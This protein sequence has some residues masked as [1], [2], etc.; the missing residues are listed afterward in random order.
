MRQLLFFGV[1]QSSKKWPFILNNMK[2]YLVLLLFS[3]SLWE[4]RAFMVPNRA[5][6]KSL[7]ELK[8]NGETRLIRGD[9]ESPERISAEKEELK[10]SEPLENWHSIEDGVAGDQFRKPSSL[11][12]KAAGIGL[13]TG[14]SVMV[15]KASIA[16]VSTWLYEDV[17]DML[18]KPVFYWPIILFPIIGAA[19][20]SCITSLQG[21][22]LKDGIETIAND[23]KTDVAY[24]GKELS[25]RISRA[26]AAVFTLGSGNSLGPEGPCVELGAGLSRL[27]GGG[28]GKSLD[29]TTRDHKDRETLL[30]AGT[31]A[32][33]SAGFSAPITGIFFALECGNRYLRGRSAPGVLA[34]GV[35]DAEVSNGADRPRADIAA[36]VLAATAASIATSLGVQESTLALQGNSYAMVSPLFELPL[37][38]GL[39]IV[40]GSISVTFNRLRD[41]F[42]ELFDSG[43]AADVPLVCRPLLGGALCG[44]VGV[45][46]PQTLFNSYTTLGHLLLP[47][48]DTLSLVLLLQLLLAKLVLSA[49]C[50]T[51][52]LVGGAFAPALF[53]GAVGGAAYHEVIAGLVDPLLHTHMGSVELQA[54]L[55]H[56]LA[57]ADTPAYATV[58]AAAT[59]GAIFRAP[60]TASMLLFELTQNHDLVL[61]VL[62]AAGLGGVFAE[63]ISRPRKQW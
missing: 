8:R 24:T 40:S 23:V 50:S 20:V 54:G 7:L 44:V 43:A 2:D 51:A 42:A 61:P 58:G 12:T 46:L 15:F 1:Q 49:F 41:A 4:S 5:R 26:I 21:P 14:I 31:A 13:G 25:L 55:E 29:D 37:Y 63:L 22:S 60:L 3:T 17:A 6:T 38:L 56:F 33:V 36:I 59:L 16:G 45:F 10:Y 53:F 30:L 9:L 62:S 27:V 52:G 47:T 28:R 32:G 35:V 39:G 19:A 18:P 48:T 57:L 34:A 11:L